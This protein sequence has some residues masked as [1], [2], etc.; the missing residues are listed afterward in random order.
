MDFYEKVNQIIGNNQR[1]ISPESE[2]CSY[3][4]A[5]RPSEVFA[6]EGTI[7]LYLRKLQYASE[8]ADELIETVFHNEDF[9][10]FY[11]V[12]KNT[13]KSAEQMCAGLRFDSFVLFLEDSTIG[14]CLSNENFMFGHFIEC[15]WNFDWDLLWTWID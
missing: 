1:F 12:D 10:S 7:A 3:Y 9:Y 2:V 6:D 15:R 4:I 14:A 13:V 8:H 11:G 5:E